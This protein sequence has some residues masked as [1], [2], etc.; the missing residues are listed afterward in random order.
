[1][2]FQTLYAR[3]TLCFILRNYCV[4]FLFLLWINV[5]LLAFNLKEYYCATRERLYDDGWR[6]KSRCVSLDLCSNSSFFL[7]LLQVS[8]PLPSSQPSLTSS[9][10]T[11]PQKLVRKTTLYRFSLADMPHIF[12]SFSRLRT[13]YIQVTYARGRGRIRF[14]QT[15][16]SGRSPWRFSP[17]WVYSS[18]DLSSDIDTSARGNGRYKRVFEREDLSLISRVSYEF[19]LHSTTKKLVISEISWNL[20]FEISAQICENFIYSCHE[21]AKEMAY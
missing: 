16:F 8:L 9:K 6:W 1:M 13:R 2:F 19:I 11:L 4:K 15:A 21:F 14:F 3:K 10:E 17:H 5:Q 20:M 18:G 12:A 7:F